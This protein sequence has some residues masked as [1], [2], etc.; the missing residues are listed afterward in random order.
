MAVPD[1]QIGQQRAV[2][3][4]LR[5]L[6]LGRIGDAVGARKQAVEMIEAAVLGV[7]HDDGLDPGEIGGDSGMGR[8]EEREQ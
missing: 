8:G 6:L 3:V 2:V 1:P 5:L 4:E 7:D